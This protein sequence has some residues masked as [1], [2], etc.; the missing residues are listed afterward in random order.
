M[1]AAVQERCAGYR[2]ARVYDLQGKNRQ[3][4]LFLA[5][6]RPVGAGMVGR[7]AGMFASALVAKTP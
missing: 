4:V 7:G 3:T 6:R 2:P 1:A 5:A